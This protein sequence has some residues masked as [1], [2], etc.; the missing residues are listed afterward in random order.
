MNNF[1][2]KNPREDL[3]YE[4]NFTNAYREAINKYNRPEEIE[5]ASL[6]AQFP[7]ALHPIQDEDLFAGRLQMGLVGLGIQGQTGGFGYYMDEEKVTRELEFATGNAKYREDLHDLLTF[8]KSKNTTTI[9][10]NQRPDELQD[11]FPSMEWKKEPLPACPIIRMAGAFIDYEK[12]LNLGL[13]GLMDLVRNRRK[14]A[15]DNNEDVVIY[16]CMLEEVELVKSVCAF[17]CSQAI[18]LMNNTDNPQRKIELKN[19]ADAL[20]KIQMDPPSSMFEALQLSWL[21]GLLIPL[22][23]HGRV[24]EYIGDFYVHDIDNGIITEDEALAM[25][26]SFFRLINHMDSETDGR[27]IIGGYGRRNP[28]NADR[29]CLTIIEACRT[30]L[31]PLPQTTLRFNSETPKAIWDAAMNCIEEGRTYPL[32]YNDDILVYAIG[33]AFDVSKEI[34][35][36]YMPLGCGEFEF[37]HFSF[38]SP[39]GSANSLKMLELAIRGG[40]DHVSNK[41]MGPKVKSLK[42]CTSYDEF[43]EEYKSIISYYIVAQAKF[44]KYE[45]DITGKMHPFLLV[46]M[47]YDGCLESGKA[48]FNGGCAHLTGALELYGNVNSANA[49]AAIKK[50]IFEEKTLT[51]DALVTAMDHNFYGYDKIRKLLLDAP[52]Y[53]NDDDYVDDIYI[54]LHN[55]IA[56]KSREQASAVG[57]K[58]YLYVTINNAQ[59]TTLARWVGATPDGRKSGMPMA[60][61]NNP[62]PG[63]DKNGLTAMLNSLAK[64][65]HDNHAGAVQNMRFTKELMASSREKVHRALI[66]YFVRG[67]AQAMITVL[68][69]EDLYNAIQKPE[70]YKDLIVRVGGFSARFVDLKKDI[71]QEIYDRVTY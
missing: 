51:V 25:L 56:E 67:G 50:H 28:K 47:L 65:S 58:A 20:L 22:L 43:Y 63:T 3:Q 34:A 71:Q 12:L 1:K 49:L 36:S 54:D 10:F 2:V 66:S 6:K 69:K 38:G 41:E 42:A 5:V 21:Y 16:D 27:V 8:W 4:I 70:E 13:N 19:I 53:G 55:Y 26:Q 64:L 60:N 62:S 23:Q 18:K 17:Y 33:K 40:Y 31:E 11:I 30:V 45:Y 46:S 57:L 37:N 48:I 39:N 9:I 14:V 7:A 68:G 29:V 32:L 52:K 15:I 24:D 61:A 59:N 44:Q 35:E